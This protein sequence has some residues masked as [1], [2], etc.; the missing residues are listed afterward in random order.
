MGI[1]RCV[2]GL[3]LAAVLAALAGCYEYHV[4][5]VVT[6]NLSGQRTTTLET[7]KTPT[8]ETLF[9]LGVDGESW[10]ETVFV[11]HEGDETRRYR[12]EQ[13]VV[14]DEL[15]AETG[16]TVLR[17]DPAGA[18]RLAT[19]VGLE[20]TKELGNKRLVYRETL[21]WNGL[22]E[23]VAAVVAV[24]Y[25]AFLRREF[26][27]LPDSLVHEFRGAMATTILLN[28]TELTASASDRD[29][30]T[31]LPSRVTEVLS[32][33]LRRAE[34][35]EELSRNLLKKTTKWKF[36][37]ELEVALPGLKSSLR[38]AIIL[39]VTMPGPIVDGNADK[40][41]GNVASF[42]VELSS[43]L[44]GPVVLEVVCQP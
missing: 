22:R 32:E 43:T 18:F 21:S 2:V 31:K 16:G 44:A 15:W 3:L 1:G 41:A 25:A 10:V 12:R 9:L 28:W 17:A 19:E 42:R 34:V 39:T 4:A 13:S 7:E 24:D 11:G 6:E 35:D 8:P 23:E 33:R 27:A 38:S 20:E 29:P 37:D 14:D 36:L 40:V 5:V 30:R 26:P